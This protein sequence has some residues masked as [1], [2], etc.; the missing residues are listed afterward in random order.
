MKR[1][2]LSKYVLLVLVA[3]LLSAGGV[4][5]LEPCDR[6][7]KLLNATLY[8]DARANYTDL[9]NQTPD[10]QCA[11][12]GILA[13]QSALAIKSYELGRAYE[14][15]SQV[16]EAKSAYLDALKNNSTFIDAQ[17]A[18]ARLN[19][20]ILTLTYSWYMWL[21]PWLEIIVAVAIVLLAIVLAALIIW[22]KII[23]LIKG[24]LKQSL[25]SLVYQR[26]YWLL[27]L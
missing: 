25:W 6:A 23:P 20:G 17:E 3:A 11:K 4:L 15:A 1:F 19:G 2:H 12:D 18:L 13:V 16:T 5:A 9:L 10:L 26:Q 21:R 24:F 7:N 14:N 22:F 27:L 8:D